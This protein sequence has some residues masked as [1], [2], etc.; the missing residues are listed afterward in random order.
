MYYTL[1]AL[2]TCN[3]YLLNCNSLHQ[4]ITGQFKLNLLRNLTS[5]QI[6]LNMK[7]ISVNSGITILCHDL[8]VFCSILN[9]QPE[10]VPFFYKSSNTS[11]S[12]ARP[13]RRNEDLS[14]RKRISIRKSLRCYLARRSFLCSE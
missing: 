7:L 14:Q 8:Y 12:Y 4:C 10:S 11:S 1:H 5:D 9:T 6:H 2:T 3:F 13:L